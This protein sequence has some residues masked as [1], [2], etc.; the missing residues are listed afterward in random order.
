MVIESLFIG[1]DGFQE[2]RSTDLG[3]VIA[4]GLR[5]D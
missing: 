5:V 1:F 3:V 4:A 2:K